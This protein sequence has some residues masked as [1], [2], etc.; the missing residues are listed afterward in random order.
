MGPLIRFRMELA[1]GAIF[2][3]LRI[4]VVEYQKHWMAYKSKERILPERVRGRHQSKD[5]VFT[6]LSQTVGKYF[7]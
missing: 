5:M 2:Y 1:L 3:E 4:V 7:L 6:E